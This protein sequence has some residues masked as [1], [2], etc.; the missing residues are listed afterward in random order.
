MSVTDTDAP[1]TVDVTA[2]ALTSDGAKSFYAKHT[3]GGLTSACSTAK[4]DYTYDGTVPTIVSVSKSGTT[5]TVL[6][7]EKVWAGTAPDAGDFV[8]TGGGAP[9]VDSLTGIP[10]TAGGADNSFE[11]TISA[12][13]TGVA[14]VTYTQNTSA[15]KRVKDVAGNE[16]ATATVSIGPPGAPSA[17]ALGTGLSATDNDDTPTVT[18]TVGETGGT[19]MLYTDSSCATSGSAATDVTDTSGTITVDVVATALTSDGAKSFYA[20][21]TKNGLA[22]GCSSAKVDYTYDGTAPTFSSVIKRG[23]K[24]TVTMSED[25][26]A[27]VL[28]D[29]T[30]FSFS[31]GTVTVSSVGTNMASTAGTAAASF[32]LNLSGTLSGSPTLSYTQNTLADKRI[33]DAVG[34]AAASVTGVT[35]NTAPTAPTLVRK[36]P[37]TYVGTDNTLT[38]TVTVDSTQTNGTVELFSDD[39][40]TTSVSDAVTVDSTTEDVTTN[41]LTVNVTYGLY[42]KHTNSANF[43]TCSENAIVYTYVATLS[44]SS[45]VS[46]LSVS[47]GEYLNDTEDESL[48]TID[49]TST[50][51]TTT[52]G[53]TV[54]V[55]GDV[56]LTF[57]V[58]PD[59]NGDWQINLTSANLNLLRGSNSPAGGR[60]IT[61]TARI[62]WNVVLTDSLSFIYDWVAPTVTVLPV[63]GGTVDSAEDDGSVLV[64]ATGV[65]DLDGVVFSISDGTDTLADKTAA[66]SAK[67]GDTVSNAVSALGLSDGDFFGAD[68]SLDGDML[69]V[70]APYGESGGSVSDTG[71]VY[72]IHDS[73]DD[74]DFSDESGANVIEIGGETAGITS[75]ASG[76]LRVGGF[77]GRGCFGC[78][79]VSC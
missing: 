52:A 70:G 15:A 76:S 46:V 5:L 22:S 13:L 47:T 40:C 18:V 58:N 68:V 6:M 71:V 31:S 41:G 17:L 66:R 2:T 77:F 7:S 19:V 29:T 34:N 16:V 11:L 63:S 20:K 1:I 14:S 43:G 51:L 49:G 64:A 67:L 25:V 62:S 53:I 65:A 3:R 26:Y 44:G 75:G 50:G 38:V 57:T 4:V 59:S 45:S 24:L 72:L 73:D 27:T 48:V 60:V 74:G 35:V 9:S 78:G 12:A 42:A 36:S 30:D 21:H 39:T 8:I 55:Q 33:T 32:D 56:P 10:N 23:T 28:P 37:T 54:V 61:V 69:A 79:G